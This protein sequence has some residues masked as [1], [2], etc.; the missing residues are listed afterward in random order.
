MR[1]F[2]PLLALL[3]SCLAAPLPA[4][5]PDSSR[6]DSA[7]HYSTTTRLYFTRVATVPAPLP[8]GVD[9]TRYGLDSLRLAWWSTGRLED[10]A[11]VVRLAPAITRGVP[12][13]P[14]DLWNNGTLAW[15]PGPF[16][17][18]QNYTSPANLIPTILAARARGQHLVL[19]LTGGAPSQYSTNGKFDLA[20]WKA[21]IDQ[22]N[23]A[24]LKAAVAAAVSDGTVLGNSLMDEPEHRNWGGVM[25]KP[26][27]D[28]MAAYAKQVF[29]TLPMGPS[30]GPNG[31]YLWRPTE[32]Y[33]V[34]DYVLNQYNF[35]VTN[36]NIAAWR[37]KVLAQARLDGN[38]AVA[39][40][41]NLIDGGQNAPRDGRW[42]CP[43]GTSDGRGNYDPACRMTAAQIRDW[44]LALGPAGCFMA[45]WE[46][47]DVTFAK[48]ANL[49][50]MAEVA[51][52]LARVP[53]RR[54]ARF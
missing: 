24:P 34:V 42:V 4:Q 16:T 30:H 37:D 50:A 20:K 11:R 12:F 19:A 45:M 7:A 49:A 35:W 28:S 33:R 8:S 54:C 25:T 27:L 44:G 32:R 17:A 6:T 3:S 53:R 38:I 9:T 39:F 40:S 14:F 1:R 29:P 41:I 52:S 5:A 21:R 26:T 10:S 51:D 36:G 23:T 46:L 2:W 43:A 31:Y 22:Y 13:G 15:G 47:N 18:S 48:A